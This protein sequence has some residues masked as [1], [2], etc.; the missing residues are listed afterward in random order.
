MCQHSLQDCLLTLDW[1]L[2]SALSYTQEKLSNAFSL[3]KGD[4]KAPPAIEL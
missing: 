4:T 2:Q 1:L 3:L